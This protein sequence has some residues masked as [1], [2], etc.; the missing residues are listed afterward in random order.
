M[1]MRIASLA[2]LCLVL[3]ALPAWA[4]YNNGPINGGIDAWPFAFGFIVSD[5]FVAD[6]S[7]VT[8]FMLGTWEFPGDM[9]TSVDW[10]I[11]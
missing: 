10:T 1:K 7:T 6:N 3:A 5:S 9:L 2:M 4:D 8:G 11:T